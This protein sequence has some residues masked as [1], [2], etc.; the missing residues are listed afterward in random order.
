MLPS[1]VLAFAPTRGTGVS[2]AKLGSTDVTLRSR[3]G[4]E[5]IRVAANRPTRAV[6]KLLQE[7]QIPAWERQQLPLVWSNDEVVAVPGIGVAVAFQAAANEAGWRIEW[8]PRK[9]G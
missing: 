9:P 8:R 1:G 6:K 3:S 7:A 5:R 2:A 4:G